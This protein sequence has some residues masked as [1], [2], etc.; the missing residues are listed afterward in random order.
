MFKYVLTLE[1]TVRAAGNTDLDVFTT[2][3]MQTEGKG[4]AACIGNVTV[5]TPTSVTIK[6]ES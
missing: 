3:T 6:G 2:G 1:G 5:T 4:D